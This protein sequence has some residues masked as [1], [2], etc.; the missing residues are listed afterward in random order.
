[1]EQFDLFYKSLTKDKEKFDLFIESRQKIFT[2][3]EHLI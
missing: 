2:E 1:M 3:L